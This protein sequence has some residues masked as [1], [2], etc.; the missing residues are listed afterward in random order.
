MDKRKETGESFWVT[1]SVIFWN[2]NVR[3]YNNVF[4]SFKAR[5]REEDSVSVWMC[6]VAVTFRYNIS[7]FDFS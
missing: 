3:V 7:E 4:F 5:S 1:D 6:T 2:N